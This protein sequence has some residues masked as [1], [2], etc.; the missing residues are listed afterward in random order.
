LDD[1]REAHHYSENITICAPQLL[2]LTR[3][4]IPLWF[5]GWILANKFEKEKS[6]IAELEMYM[7]EPD[8]YME[9]ESWT[10]GE[11]NSCCLRAEEANLF[12]DEEKETISM[13]LRKAREVGA[14][15]RRGGG[16]R[17]GRGGLYGV[18]D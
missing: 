1:S 17:R 3:A 4:G 15:G 9:P 13:I 11:S 16:P 2:H 6:P 5:N 12:T 18:D 8:H 10:I 7:K 14:V